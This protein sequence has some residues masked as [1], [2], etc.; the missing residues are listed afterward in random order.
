MPGGLVALLDDI[1]AKAKAILEKLPGTAGVE[2]ETAG[3]PKSIVVEL[4]DQLH[5]VD[6]IAG[7]VREH[8]IE[9]RRSVLAVLE[10]WIEGELD[11]RQLGPGQ[12]ATVRH[13][14]QRLAEMP[15]VRAGNGNV[16]AD[17]RPHGSQHA[18]KQRRVDSLDY[19]AKRPDR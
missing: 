11:A 12:G 6:K 16:I 17:R 7:M 4:V 3:R 5:E 10:Q 18:R 2:F 13:A 8:P 1:A 19:H 9:V 15:A 14:R